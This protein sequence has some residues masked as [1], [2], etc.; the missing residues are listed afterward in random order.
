MRVLV[1]DG[2]VPAALAVIQSLGRRGAEVDV[3]GDLKGRTHGSRYISR[4]IHG[5]VLRETAAYGRWVAEQVEHTDYDLV[6]PSAEFSMRALQQLGPKHA[7]R[8]KAVLASYESMEIAL[9]KT[10]TRLL[11]DRLG[12]AV[13]ET[14]LVSSGSTDEE[15]PAR[16][17]VVLKTTASQLLVGG[18]YQYVQPLI[19]QSPAARERFLENWLSHCDVEEQEFLPGNGWGVECLY[20]HGEIRWHFIH[21]RL[22]EYPLSGGGSSYRRSVGV[23]PDLLEMARAVL[24]SLEWHGVAMVEFRVDEPSG[25]VTL[26]EINPRVWGSLPLAI[27]CGVDFPAGLLDVALGRDLDPQPSYRHGWRMRW[28]TRDLE[29]M[30]SNWIA[31]HEDPLLLTRPRLRS[32]LE[33]MRVLGGREGWDHFSWRDPVPGL[34]E[35][36]TL[37]SRFWRGLAHRF[38]GQA[39]HARMR[40]LHRQNLAR[41]RSTNLAG[42]V[43]NFVCYGNICRSPLAEAL[44]RASSDL[45]TVESTGLHAIAGR[46]TPPR[47]IAAAREVGADL[48]A[49]RARVISERHVEE[50]DV[51]VVMDPTNFEDLLD[52]FPSAREKTILL[53]LVADPPVLAVPDPID[54][55]EEGI[56]D[57]VQ[58]VQ[59][60]VAR[61]L[62]Q[63]GTPDRSPD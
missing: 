46:G 23:R 36:G 26:L 22:H 63:V 55:N 8:S 44:A 15:P 59:R 41:L 53:G 19:A 42:P 10:H 60:A 32:V 54:R 34:M 30:R 62:E 9:D 6:V 40:R 33:W 7:V 35:V 61:L 4:R 2:Q 57:S 3:I 5:G 24:D 12:L 28:L 48:S 45:W 20:E 17:P 38:S 50:A 29:W 14:R 18:Q 49:H 11:G 47:V 25:R 58:L 31:D 51:L 52:R 43:V 27:S 1:L 16:Y 37:F 56:M 21:E 39:Q 13:P